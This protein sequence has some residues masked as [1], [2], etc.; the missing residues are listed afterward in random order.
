M[1]P[2]YLENSSHFDENVDMRSTLGL[3]LIW[4]V[5]FEGPSMK[6][7]NSNMKIDNLAILCFLV[8]LVAMVLIVFACID[9]I[10]LIVNS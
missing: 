2:M 8:L 1:L 10:I 7:S 6:A 9:L 3:E 5:A 4:V